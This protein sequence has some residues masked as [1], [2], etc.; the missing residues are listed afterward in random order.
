MKRKFTKWHKKGLGAVFAFAVT[1]CTGLLA[2][3][4]TAYAST[5]YTDTESNN[6][7]EE[8][9]IISKMHRLLLRLFQVQ[10]LCIVM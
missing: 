5:I 9:Q 1:L 4:Q 7:H 3:G 2:S 8:A 10:H 6:S